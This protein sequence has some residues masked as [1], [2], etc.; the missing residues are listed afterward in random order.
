MPFQC[1]FFY[2]CG[3]SRQ[4]EVF[5]KS[6]IA[7]VVIL[8]RSRLL[9]FS[10]TL[11]KLWRIPRG[12]CSSSCMW[13]PVWSCESSVTEDWNYTGDG[14]GFMC[15]V[16]WRFQ[17]GTYR[18]TKSARYEDSEPWVN[19]KT[20]KSHLMWTGSQGK[21]ASIGVIWSNFV[22]LVTSLAAAF[23]T[24]CRLLNTRRVKTKKQPI[25]IVK[26]RRNKR[27]NYDLCVTGG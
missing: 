19:N 17:D 15:V 20:S 3:L 2:K 24:N 22:V 26:V 8:Q 23:C 12:I 9:C 5:L 13:N 16:F 10:E 1:F 18:N 21:L 6:F 7:N 27:K 25:T 11:D 4:Q 14:A